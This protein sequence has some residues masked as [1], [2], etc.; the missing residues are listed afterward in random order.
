MTNTTPGLDPYWDVLG[1][2]VPELSVEEQQT[3]VALYRELGKGAALDVEQLASS[4]GI[5]ASEARGRLASPAIESLIYADEQGRVVGFG[6]LATVPT[7]HRFEVGQR[8]LWT[9]CAWDSLF[10]PQLLDETARVSSSDPE[11][12]QDI[13][14]VVTPHGVECVGPETVVVSFLLPDERAF[15]ESAANLMSTFC[16]F[17]F[18]FA[19]ADSGQRWAAKHPGTLL[20]SVDDAFELGRRLNERTFG[21]ALGGT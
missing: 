1:A 7:K 20:Y 10:I 11:T 21:R 6:G 8:E 2:A 19:S 15:D 16:H 3:A 4:L 9:W 17:V 5:S 14:L 12:G 18:F 13:S